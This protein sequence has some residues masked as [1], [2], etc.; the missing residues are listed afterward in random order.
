MKFKRSSWMSKI[1]I[2]LPA[3]AAVVT[4]VSLQAGLAEKRQ[5]KAELEAQV[6]TVGQENQRLREAL[7]ET[8]TD[9]AT[10]QIARQTLGMVDSGEIIFYDMGS[11]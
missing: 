6:A 4:L 3:A 11:D 1:I 8:D 5:E 10:K 2:L 9:A 7:D